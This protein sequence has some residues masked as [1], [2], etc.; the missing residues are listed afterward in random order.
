M[1]MSDENILAWLL[2][3]GSISKRISVNAAFKLEIIRD[4]LDIADDDEYAALRLKREPIR[5]RE[6]TLSA[7]NKPIVYARSVIPERTSNR[8]Y[9][10]LKTIGSRPLGD[11]LFQNDVFIKTDRFFARFQITKNRVVW[12]RRTHYSVREYPLI[13]LEVFLFLGH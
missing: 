3:E 7:D 1:A 13:V 9:P 12:G 2:E 5:I 6:V 10:G 8:G 4:S 11:L